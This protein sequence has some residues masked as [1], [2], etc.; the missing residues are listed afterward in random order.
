MTMIDW[1]ARARDRS[2]R[3]SPQVVPAM[4]ASKTASTTAAAATGPRR[5][6]TNFLSR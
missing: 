1:T 3:T 6:R 2:A 5:R 4:P